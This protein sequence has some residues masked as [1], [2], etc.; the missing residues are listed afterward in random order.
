MATFPPVAR[1]SATSVAEN[2]GIRQTPIMLWTLSPA[3]LFPMSKV[4]CGRLLPKVENAISKREEKEEAAVNSPLLLCV[5]VM[6][7]LP[8]FCV[9][10]RISLSG[11]RP[12]HRLPEHSLSFRNGVF[13]SSTSDTTKIVFLLSAHYS[14]DNH[15]SQFD[16]HG[17]VVR[18][19]AA[20]ADYLIFSISSLSHSN[21]RLV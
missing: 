11:L 10:K 7:V 12:G 1:M 5:W 15:Q 2:A 20:P 19:D 6:W 3:A 16:T 8:S 9:F 13:S 18:F 17:A 14:T 21:S 4:I